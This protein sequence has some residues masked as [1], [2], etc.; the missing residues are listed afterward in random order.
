[1]AGG[2]VGRRN[3]LRARWERVPERE[4]A[5]AIISIEFL[6]ALLCWLVDHALG[7]GVA[8]VFV[9]LWLRRLA[10]YPWRLLVELLLVGIFAIAAAVGSASISVA[11]VLAAAFGLAWIPAGKRRWLLP[12]LALLLAVSYPFFV[13]HLFTIPVFGAFPS[14]ST[15][16]YMVVFIMMAVGLN[17]VVGY[18][19]LLDLGYVAFYAVGAYT[20]GWF[21]SSQFAGQKCPN[22][23]FNIST[24]P[25][26]LVPKLNF[27]LGGVGVPIGS[28]GIH[29]SI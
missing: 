23:R 18:A 1:M 29:I 2:E 14:V 20:A 4:R 7:Y 28:G 24:C 6:F 16:T 3:Q 17:M 19:G 22:P 21:A 12:A 15:G 25:D 11:L 8:V 13:D 26:A 10:P 27:S 5:I 9:T